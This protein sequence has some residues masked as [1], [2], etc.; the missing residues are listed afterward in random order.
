MPRRAAGW[1][2]RK[3]KDSPYW[4]IYWVED[5]KERWFST[6]FLDES[7]ARRAA[8]GIILRE[9]IQAQSGPLAEQLAAQLTL[10]QLSD[11]WLDEVEKARGSDYLRRLE[12]DMLNYVEPRWAHPA[13]ITSDSWSAAKEELHAHPSV[14][15]RPLTWRSI[16]NLANTLRHF[17]RWC[18]AKGYVTSVPELKSPSTKAQNLEKA[19]RRAFDEEQQEA[20]LWAL[21]V[22]GE[23]R[24]LHVYTTLFET[25]QRKS[26]IAALTLRW[27]DFR[28]E[29]IT[30]PGQFMKGRKEK[31]IDLTPRAAE[32]ILAEANARKLVE[33][34]KP[35]FGPFDYHQRQKQKWTDA[36]GVEHWHEGG[37]VFGRACKFAGIDRHGL[38]A[39]H[40]TRTTAL[41]LAGQN[42]EATLSGLMAQAG[43]DTASI[44]E[45]YMKPQLK[46]AR[47]ITRKKG[48]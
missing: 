4:Y 16:A 26:T 19:P 44:V 5:K 28:G 29:T 33:L 15:G 1:H 24:A 18:A 6:G 47:R 34:D 37:G 22:L 45:V 12:T 40:S 30:L 17:L 31:V 11:R 13:E 2:P 9:G 14:R 8:P 42:P 32:A 20:F 43:I 35:V 3:R 27:C 46:A 7:E 41:T 38:V 36:A 10:K 39:H 48:A 25:W 23:S 21:A